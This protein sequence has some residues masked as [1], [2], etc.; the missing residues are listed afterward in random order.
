MNNQRED[1]C[2][3]DHSDK[4]ADVAALRK[5]ATKACSPLRK[6]ILNNVSTNV[7]SDDHNDKEADAA[8]FR[9]IA[10]K[11]CPAKPHTRQLT[12]D[13]VLALIAIVALVYLLEL[14]CFNFFGMSQPQA[15]FVTYWAWRAC[16]SCV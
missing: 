4:Q 3:D 12:S 2:S 15:L 8:A 13:D 14:L 5:K 7:Y 16:K 6:N 11:A 10:P 9:K 1:V